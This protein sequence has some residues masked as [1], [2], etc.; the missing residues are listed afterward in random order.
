LHDV[1]ESFRA[2][3]QPSTSGKSSHY[4]AHREGCDAA[5]QL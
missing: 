4:H 3:V 2:T 1:T 5:S